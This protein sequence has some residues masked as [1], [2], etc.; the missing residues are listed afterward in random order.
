MT[1]CLEIQGVDFQVLRGDLEGSPHLWWD[2]DL[3]NQVPLGSAKMP[4]HQAKASALETHDLRRGGRGADS[5][6]K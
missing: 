5:G 2:V 3:Q 6:E 1:Q 4:R